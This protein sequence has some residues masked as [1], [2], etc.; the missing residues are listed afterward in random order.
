MTERGPVDVPILITSLGDYT[1]WFGERLLP[2][3][4]TGAL[5]PAHRCRGLLHQQRQARL[6]DAHSRYRRRDRAARGAVRPRHL[7]AA[8]TPW[9]CARPANSAGRSSPGRWCT[10]WTA[11]ASRW[12]IGSASA[13]AAGRSTVK[14]SPRSG[15]HQHTRAPVVPLSISHPPPAVRLEQLTRRRRGTRQP[16]PARAA[17]GDNA[18]VAAA[19]IATL[20][21]SLDSIPARDRQAPPWQH[22]LSCDAR[23]RRHWREFNCSREDLRSTDPAAA[24]GSRSR[25]PRSARSGIVLDPRRQQQPTA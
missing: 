20:A 21:G 24:I 5:L 22:R 15:R 16:A 9:S 13:T 18:L 6:S 14:W 8:R 25:I 12:A 3:S 17:A 4:P 11:P 19:D 1:R 23:R 2:T 7:P 10:R